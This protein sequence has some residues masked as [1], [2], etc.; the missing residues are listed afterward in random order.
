MVAKV[1]DIF[2][3]WYNYIFHTGKHTAAMRLGLAK[4]LVSYEDIIYYS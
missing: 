4:G 1:L 3:V 2:R